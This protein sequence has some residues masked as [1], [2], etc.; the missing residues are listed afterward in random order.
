MMSHGIQLELSRVVAVM[1]NLARQVERLTRAQQ[2]TRN[3][4]K[5]VTEKLVRHSL[6][7]LDLSASYIQI[8]NV[9][10]SGPT[11]QNDIMNVHA[12]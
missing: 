3:E 8:C 6:L 1:E 2:D 7:L 12:S 4:L 11:A 5:A 10:T 9:Y